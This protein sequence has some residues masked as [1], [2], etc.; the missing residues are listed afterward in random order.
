VSDGR[1]TIRFSTAYQAW[2]AAAGGDKA[3]AVRALMVLGAAALD[4]PGAAR[5]ARRLLETE[6]ADDIAGALLRL[7]DNRQTTGRQPADAHVAA[8]VVPHSN[9]DTCIQVD[10]VDDPFGSIGIEV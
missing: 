7:A 3:D 2:I 8:P 1:L 4:L 10:R 9:K 5:E 6:I